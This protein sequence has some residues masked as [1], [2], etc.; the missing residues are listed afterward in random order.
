MFVTMEIMS[1]WGNPSWVGLTEVEFFDLNYTKLYV[2]PHDVDVQ[3]TTE[4]GELGFL[5]NRNAAVSG[6][7]SSMV[8]HCILVTFLCPCMRVCAKGVVTG[9][10]PCCQQ[11]VTHLADQQ[12]PAQACS[13]S[14]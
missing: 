9:R 10:G 5:V 4:P 13:G 7:H 8:L 14:L 3:N 2:S 6:E 1:N 11:P 12:E